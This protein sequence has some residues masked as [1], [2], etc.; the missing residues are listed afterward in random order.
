MSPHPG[1]PPSFWRTLLGETGFY[2][3]GILIVV[4]WAMFVS[5]VWR[6]VS[7]SSVPEDV[8]GSSRG[9]WFG[10][11]SA[12]TAIAI[13]MMLWTAKR[14]RD[15]LQHGVEV[16]G[17][18][19]SVSPARVV[20]RYSYAGR[21]WS[22][23]ISGSGTR[24]VAEYDP[25]EGV[26]VLLDPGSPKRC[27]LRKGTVSGDGAPAPSGP[28]AGKGDAWWQTSGSGLVLLG[29]AVFFYV[30]LTRFEKTGGT[31]HF[32]GPFALL[33]GVSGKWGVV[34]TMG[35]LGL[36]MLYWGVQAFRKKQ[37]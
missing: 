32:W 25:G 28:Q 1:R 21:E 17:S 14:V 11:A 18:I 34:L 8:P 27:L 16:P 9:F 26:T 15:L 19:V 2:M 31:Y 12:M 30:D 4:G 24:D 6:G 3:G 13:P 22:K 5:Y 37:P 33:Y 29:L 23:I 7:F 36:A 35:L 20:F 10:M